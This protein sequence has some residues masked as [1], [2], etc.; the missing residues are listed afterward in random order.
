MRLV[1]HYHLF[2]LFTFHLWFLHDF[3]IFVV[4]SQPRTR[5]A[6][7]EW[8]ESIK[9]PCGSW[10]L[11]T[12]AMV[13]ASAIPLPQCGQCWMHGKNMKKVL[14]M[15]WKIYSAEFNRNQ[16]SKSTKILSQLSGCH[17]S[18]AI[19]VG[20]HPSTMLLGSR[21]TLNATRDLFDVVGMSLR[22]NMT[23]LLYV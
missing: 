22:H 8:D 5:T 1:F 21:Q 3:V 11:C 17:H 14:E 19:G 15:T 6:R 12:P 2:N 7:D 9:V 10:H 20:C 16:N 18:L 23:Q 13:S 4:L